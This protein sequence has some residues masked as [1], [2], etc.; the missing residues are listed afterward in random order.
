MRTSH[1]TTLDTGLDDSLIT[2]LPPRFQHKFE[3]LRQNYS[4]EL[5]TK[6][7]TIVQNWNHLQYA[8]DADVFE[9]LYRAVHNLAGTGATFGYA[10]LGSIAREI[11][12]SLKPVLEH[13]AG[14][15]P[16]QAHYLMPLIIELCRESRFEDI[17]LKPSLMLEVWPSHDE[18]NKLSFSID[19]SFSCAQNLATHLLRLE[20]ESRWLYLILQSE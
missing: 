19:M 3:R 20:Y 5:R 2:D 11:A 9:S 14:I 15:T 16:S 17:I 12:N 6:L 8:W 7:C 18:V 4:N 10:A 1:L 13:R